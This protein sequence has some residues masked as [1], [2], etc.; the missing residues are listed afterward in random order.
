MLRPGP[1]TA[2]LRKCPWRLLALRQQTS[3]ESRRSNLKQKRAAAYSVNHPEFPK[4]QLLLA[5]SG[6]ADVGVGSS[7]KAEPPRIVGRQQLQ[8]LCAALQPRQADR[9]CTVLAWWWIG[10]TRPASLDRTTQLLL[11]MLMRGP[12][13]ASLQNIDNGRRIIDIFSKAMYIHDEASGATS[14]V[15]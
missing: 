6:L 11:L 7:D 1:S 3:R 4:Q 8:A 13:A 9:A 12:Q 10:G 2:K 5:S 15:R 14:G